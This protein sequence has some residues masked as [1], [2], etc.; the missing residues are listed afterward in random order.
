M[1]KAWIAPVDATEVTHSH[2]AKRADRT[3]PTIPRPRAD[4][5]VEGPLQVRE[6]R[7]YSRHRLYVDTAEGRVVGWLSLNNGA[8]KL[9]AEAERPRFQAAI[10]GWFADALPGA[11]APAPMATV[12]SPEP[13]AV[14]A[15]EPGIPGPRHRRAGTHRAG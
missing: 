8:I 9:T 14:H 3:S 4:R 15:Q 7:K 1:V 10:V 12:P 2:A 11:E 5:A 13:S 6:W